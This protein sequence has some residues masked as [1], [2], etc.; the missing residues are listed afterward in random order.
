VSWASKRAR[1]VDR[2]HDSEYVDG[3]MPALLTPAPAVLYAPVCVGAIMILCLAAG[4]RIACLL[5]TPSVDVTRGE[6][7]VIAVV[8]GAGAMQF[9]PFALGAFGV[10]S[11]A[12]LGVLIGGLT[13]L[14]IADLR[15]LA[16]VALRGLTPFRVSQR[17]MI[18]LVA[19]IVPALVCSLLSALSPTLDPDGLSYHLTVPKRWLMSG[20]LGYLPTYTFSNT[21][22]GVEMLFTIALAFGGDAAAKLLHWALGLSGAW[23]V[24][25]AGVRYRS[26]TVGT[27]SAV[28]Y[29]VGPAG[30]CALMG[31]AYIEG[32]TALAIAATTLAWL[33]W[34]RTRYPG[35]LRTAALLLSITVSF[36]LTALVFAVVLFG[37]TIA[38]IADEARQHEQISIGVAQGFLVVVLTA[39]CVLPWFVRSAVV[40]GNPLFPLFARALPTRDFS[41]PTAAM[42]DLYNRYYL[43]ASRFGLQWSLALRQMIL[44]GA[45]LVVGGLTLFL[46]L[47]SRTFITRASALVLGL[48]VLLQLSAAG[49]YLRYW[50]PVL[51]VLLLPVL[52]FMDQRLRLLHFRWLFVAL[53]AVGSVRQ[54][55]SSIA[56]AEYDLGG[57]IRSAFGFES[58]PEFLA[59][60]LELYP[61]Y[62]TIN[63]QLPLDSRVAL[64]YS[65]RGFYIDRTTFCAEFPQDALGFSNWEAFS[66]NVKQLGIT[67]FL[68]PTEVVEGRGIPPPDYS[69]PAMLFRDRE[70]E[71]IARLLASRGRRIAKA[72]EQGLYALDQAVEK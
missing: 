5:G 36:K 43:W 31:F 46:T 68:A 45:L 37:L 42:Y 58:Y 41:P 7:F 32:A 14:L 62:E 1:V 55:R 48:G 17:W 38:S 65:C 52:A 64:S 47:R 67:H 51:P 69:A 40:T 27:I 6:Q 16:S 33:L 57:I 9:V 29:L 50:T 44:A 3:H 18:V 35:W 25:R 2:V 70:N 22:M 71:Y 56:D 13:L 49:L 66:S 24:Y 11:N 15:A 20:G 8:L 26:E 54:A 10:L 19:T 63:R 21:P 23:A 12:A 39:A 72:G 53:V 60:H 28:L 59:R 30:V 4:R 34:F 61:L